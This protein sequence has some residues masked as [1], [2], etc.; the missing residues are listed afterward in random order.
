MPEPPWFAL[1]RLIHQIVEQIAV[2]E[3]RACQLQDPGSPF[4]ERGGRVHAQRFGF[5]HLQLEVH[6]EPFV[7]VQRLN[8][9]HA[10]AVVLPYTCL[11]RARVTMF[12]SNLEDNG[13]FRI[14]GREVKVCATTRG[15]ELGCGQIRFM[16]NGRK[17]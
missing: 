11:N 9:V 7:V 14:T 12:I 1:E 4:L 8:G 13:R 6:K 10:V 15:L 2:D 17:A 3:V 5:E 16:Q